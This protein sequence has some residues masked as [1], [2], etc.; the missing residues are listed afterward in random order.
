MG[1]G[2]YRSYTL[3]K[4]DPTVNEPV[5]IK[6]SI[7][8][9]RPDALKVPTGSDYQGCCGFRARIT[10]PDGRTEEAAPRAPIDGGAVA[11][12]SREIEP[13]GTY[14]T[15]LLA[16]KWFGFD[17][18]GRYLLYVDNASLLVDTTAPKSPYPTDGQIVIDVGPRDTGR[19]E[20]ICADLENRMMNTTSAADALEAEDVL[21]HI[22]DP[23][24]VPHI[25]RVLETKETMT[26]FLVDALA[27]IGDNAAV[28]ALILRLNSPWKDQ[29]TPR[30]V[31]GA[32]DEI[33]KKTK[34]VTIKLKI[35]ASR[36]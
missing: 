14:S 4:V 11:F 34:D 30:S 2:V 6:F 8:N 18:P 7:E 10:R 20:Q 13:F 12:A 32:L 1:P 35:Q 24:A 28:D 26:P 23:V 25:A 27:H 16:N 17:T 9:R 21:T 31:R 19:L 36:R 15:T 29:D 22:T 33:E 3:V 5:V